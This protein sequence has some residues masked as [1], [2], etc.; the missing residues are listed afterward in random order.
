MVSS[1]PVELEDMR[2]LLK[3]LLATMHNTNTEKIKKHGKLVQHQM[4]ADRSLQ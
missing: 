4:K 1:K 3:E 2:G